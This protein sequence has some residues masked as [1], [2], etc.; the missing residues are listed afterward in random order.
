LKSISIAV[1]L[2]ATIVT[3]GIAQSDES[4][5]STSYVSAMTSLPA[6]PAN[7]HVRSEDTRF[8]TVLRNAVAR[9]ST[10]RDLVGALNR[11]DVIVYIETRKMRKMRTGFSG[12]LVH[13]VVAAGSHRY[14]KVVINR[15]L[16]G[17]RLTGAIAHELQHAREVAETAGVRSAADMRALFTRLDSGQCVL[18]RNCTETD[19]ALRLH[20]MVLEELRA[21]R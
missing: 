21:A 13:H 20:A 12:Y 5:G 2:S 17:D 9:S 14:L 18:M 15:D 6:W 8:V 16:G 1:V 19:A 4:V 11:S 7:A 10:F 3:A